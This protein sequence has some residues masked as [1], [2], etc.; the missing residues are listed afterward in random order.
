MNLL[1]GFY[2]YNDDIEP[3]SMGLYTAASTVLN[4]TNDMLEDFEVNQ[5]IE[6]KMLVN[7]MQQV[8]QEQQTAI[9]ANA[10][11]LRY[12]DQ[13]SKKEAKDDLEEIE[14]LIEDLK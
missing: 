14:Q 5:G 8:Q 13:V 9:L 6:F 1:I 4:A 11:S 10:D 3:S 2:Q 12:R 7:E